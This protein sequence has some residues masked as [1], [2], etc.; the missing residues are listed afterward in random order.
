MSGPERH[1]P[2]ERAV[3]FRDMGGYAAA[4]GRRTR[5]RRLFRS[6][7]LGRFTPDDVAAF[8]ALGIR[9]AYDFRAPFECERNPSAC[10]PVQE[11]VSLVIDPR[12]SHDGLIEEWMTRA[13]AEDDIVRLQDSVY[14]EIVDEHGARY[15]EM[16]Q[17]ILRGEG[18]PFLLHCSG[19]KD[20]TGIGSALILTALGVPEE[21]IYDDYLETLQSRATQLYTRKLAQRF[22]AE[23][24]AEPEE[25][26]YVRAMRL[27]GVTRERLDVAFDAMKARSGSAA[28]YL[29][30]EIGLTD[31][32]IATLRRWYLEG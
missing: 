10:R 22:I 1:L 26:V 8:H 24:A 25:G 7:H 21:T 31:S 5:W 16:F 6:G 32:D 17:D 4:D 3:N 13:R 15:R 18:R 30:D 23:G 14:R 28:G 29:K 11:A 19:G 2:F 27:F 20:R 12:A 9:T